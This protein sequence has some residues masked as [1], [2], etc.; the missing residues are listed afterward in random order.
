MMNA[1][2][3]VLFLAPIVSLA[4]GAAIALTILAVQ[5]LSQWRLRADGG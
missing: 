2:R 5:D 1:G 3:Q 4:P